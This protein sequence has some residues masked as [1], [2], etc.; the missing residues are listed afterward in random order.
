MKQTNCLIISLVVAAFAVGCKPSG[1]KSTAEQVESLKSRTIDA[2]QDLKDYSFE[3]K[4]EYVAKMESQ[5]AEINKGLDQLAAKI[6][7][8]NAAARAE[9]KPKLD[10]LRE[11]TARLS[12]QIDRVRSATESTWDEV[13]LGFKEGYKELKEGFQ[14]A[15]RWVGERISP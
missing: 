9:A 6:E 7:K 15:R 13:K 4:A 10:A 1:E 12:K 3:Q 11:Q 8:S 14:Q 2:A 5:L